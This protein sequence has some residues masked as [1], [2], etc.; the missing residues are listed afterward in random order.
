M[1]YF[2]PEWD[3]RVDPKYDF[4]NDAHSEEHKKDPINNDV[5]M[6]N[7]FGLENVPIDGVLVSR[8]TIMQSKNKYK[9]VLREGIHKALKLPDSFEILGDCGAFGYVKEKV[10]PFDPTEILEYYSKCGFNYGVS[11]DHLVVTQFKKEKK[12]RLQ[13][14]YENAVKAYHEWCK[15]FKN[16][17]Q[18]L[19]AVQ[20]WDVKDY[21]KM[22]RDYIKLGATHV[23]FGGLARS[24]TS[25]ITQ[26]I[27]ELIKEI[28]TSKKVPIYLHFFGLARFSLFPKFQELED[29]GVKVGFDSASYLRKAWLSAASTQLNYLTLEGEG[30][31][32]I[33][34]P[35]V[36][37]KKLKTANTLAGKVD[38]NELKSL[39]KECLNKLRLY[40]KGKEN[41]ENVLF[42]LSK[43]NKALGL[44]TSLIR[45][46]KRTLEDKPWKLCNCPICK[47]IGIEVVIFRGNNRNRRRGFHNIYVFYNILKNPTLWSR[48]TKK[49]REEQES[50]LYSLNKSE[51]VLVITGCTK[52]KL[53]YNNS[54]RTPAKEMYQGRLFKTVK[55]YCEAMGYDYVI[56]SAKY[57]LLFPDEVIEGYEK[58][59]QTKEDIQTIR[60]LVEKR[61]KPILDKY[62]KILVIAGEKYR[63]VLRYLWDE[64]FITVK[65]K[66]YGDLCRIIKKAIPKGRSILEFT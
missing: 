20:G 17:F 66:G 27:N 51:K 53:A 2:I 63:E 21:L 14:T 41:L 29:L 22:Y 49:R 8:I 46:Y 62:E 6:W 5:Y 54:L 16:D 58:V 31:S 28:K 9:R 32:A 13:I 42:S 57:G 47:K 64:R 60:P 26:L 24:P 52:K 4:V 30:Y 43:F 1:K 40:D 48:F 12:A 10:P 38:I 33:R 61:L 36:E 15:R 45:Y 3:D 34:I 50:E 25:F 19:L 11:V 23:A 35:F 59:L 56:I 44:N 18:L 65:S 39:E 55:K 7:I 37:K